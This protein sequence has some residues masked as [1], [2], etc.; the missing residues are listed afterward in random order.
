MASSGALLFLLPFG[1]KPTTPRITRPLASEILDCKKAQGR[2]F[3]LVV[4]ALHSTAATEKTDKKRHLPATEYDI[5]PVS[6]VPKIP[7][8][9]VSGSYYWG[10]PLED[11]ELW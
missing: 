5:A 8:K 7:D 6:V 1:H 9:L 10:I 11:R 3:S 4:P 2:P